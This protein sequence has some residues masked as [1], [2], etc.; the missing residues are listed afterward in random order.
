MAAV[1]GVEPTG[2]VGDVAGPG[3]GGKQP[4]LQAG[5]GPEGPGLALR[6]GEEDNIH[7][8]EDD[9]HGEEDDSQL[10]LASES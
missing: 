2:E 9:S 1:V 6:A 8:E 10:L 5:L 7:G 3:V 4:A